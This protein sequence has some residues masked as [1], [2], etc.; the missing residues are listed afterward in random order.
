MNS[1]RRRELTLDVAFLILSLLA[2][3]IFVSDPVNKLQWVSAIL[4]T[5]LSG[6]LLAVFA[7]NIEDVGRIGLSILFGVVVYVI[8]GFV[9]YT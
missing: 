9:L 5:V 3:H 1:K 4:V 7:K 8:V 2:V 6:T